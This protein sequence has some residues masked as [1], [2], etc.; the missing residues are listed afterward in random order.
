MSKTINNKVLSLDNKN[1]ETVKTELK[2]NDMAYLVEIDGKQIQ[3]W[4][5]YISAIQNNFKLPTPCFDSVDRYL[6]WMRD[7][8]WLKKE[9][10]IL[11]ITNYNLFLKNNSELKK[12]IIEDFV[13]V[14]LPFWQE[15]VEEVV[16]DGKAKPFM[17]YLVD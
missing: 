12:Q 17:V 14:I 16:V 10:Y 1:I 4:E 5:D 7:L 11:I 9:E 3:S 6:D 15:E 8:D 2:S 13:D